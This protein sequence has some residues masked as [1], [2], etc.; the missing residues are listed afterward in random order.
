M[1]QETS[2]TSIFASFCTIKGQD[3]YYDVL[4]MQIAWFEEKELSIKYACNSSIEL[5]LDDS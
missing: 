3:E 2:F 5:N 1:R 4:E